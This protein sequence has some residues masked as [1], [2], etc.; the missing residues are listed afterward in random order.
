MLIQLNLTP[1]Y[2]HLLDFLQIGTGRE[3]WDNGGD[4]RVY[5][6]PE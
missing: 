4:E 5:R 6:R 3:Q 1:R 2:I